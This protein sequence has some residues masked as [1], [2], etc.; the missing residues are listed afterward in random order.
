MG[1]VH[2]ERVWRVCQWGSRN[3]HTLIAQ[4]GTARKSP[5]RGV[6]VEGSIVPDA[7]Y[8]LLGATVGVHLERVWSSCQRAS[9]NTHRCN[10][11]RRPPPSQHLEGSFFRPNGRQLVESVWSGGCRYTGQHRRLYIH[12]I[13]LETSGVVWS[14]E[15]ATKNV[16]KKALNY[17]LGVCVPT[18]KQNA[19]KIRV[20]ELEF[21]SKLSMYFAAHKF[22]YAT[23]PEKLCKT[24]DI[25][26]IQN[27]SKR[28]TR[29]ISHKVV[30]VIYPL[31][32]MTDPITGKKIVASKYRDEIDE[33]VKLFGKLDSAFEY[34]K[35]PRRGSMEGTRDFSNKKTFVKYNDDPTDTDPYKVNPL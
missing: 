5:E 26:L 11:V 2:L 21:D 8:W 18:T 4:F 14:L 27:L 7:A 35:A 23:D 6:N 28:L 13:I 30:E 29:L 25:V 1:G 10:K 31:G 17:L 33:D 15:M 3:T 20:H 34:D 9:R 22:I 19:A 12:L 24:G 32:D 16:T